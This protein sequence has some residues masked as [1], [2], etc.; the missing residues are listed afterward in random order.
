MNSK[1]ALT[2]FVFVIAVGFYSCN[3]DSQSTLDKTEQTDNSNAHPKLILTAQGVK[4]IRAQLG[5]IPIFDKTL[6]TVKEE[7]DTEI[8]SG[9]HMP[10]P[11]DYSGGYSHDRHKRNFVVLQKQVYY[12]KFLMTKNMPSMLKT[13]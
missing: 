4:D 1:S 2:I 8:A 6:A 11:K 12:I 13:C 10:I 7:I 9:I 3:N 5:T